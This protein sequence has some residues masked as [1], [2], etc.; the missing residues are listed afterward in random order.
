VNQTSLARG[1][2]WSEAYVVVA[3]RVRQHL[4]VVGAPALWDHL[5]PPKNDI[6]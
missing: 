1:A 2:V 5:S 4:D 3:Q 6:K